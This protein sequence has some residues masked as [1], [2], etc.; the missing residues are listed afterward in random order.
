[1]QQFSKHYITCLLRMIR[2]GST[3]LS[4]T[5]GAGTQRAPGV[6]CGQ[7]TQCSAFMTDY[8]LVARDSLPYAHGLTRPCSSSRKL[9]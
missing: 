8:E 5:T 3:A 2:N 7:A 9:P 1:M 4:C 6:G